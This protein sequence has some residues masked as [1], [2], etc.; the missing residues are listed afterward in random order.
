MKLSEMQQAMD[1]AAAVFSRAD[2]CA[3]QMARML[4]GRL[5]KVSSRWILKAMKSE[6]ASYNA[7]TGQWKEEK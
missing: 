6:L 7:H 3:D 5:R 1:D 4:K 2:M